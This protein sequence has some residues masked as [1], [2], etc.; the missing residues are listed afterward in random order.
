MVGLMEKMMDCSLAV[1]LEERKD[2]VMSLERMTDSLS[3][4][5]LVER[6]ADLMVRTM[7]YLSHTYLKSSL[8]SYPN[9]I[10]YRSMLRSQAQQRSKVA[11]LGSHSTF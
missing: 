1:S 4:A 10:L 3:D 5:N 6:K 9:Y 7:D 11:Y 2:A 8:S